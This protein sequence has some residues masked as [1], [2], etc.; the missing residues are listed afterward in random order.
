M[1]SLDSLPFELSSLKPDL[2]GDLVTPEDKEYNDAIAR[3][4]LVAQR[5]A[6]AVVYVKDSEDV[7]LTLKHIVEH[8][9][10][11]VVKGGGHSCS[12]VSSCEGG[13]V[14]DLAR[15][16]NGVSVDAEKKLAYVGGGAVWKSVD[17]KGMEY[18][19]ATVGGTVNH[20]GVLCVYLV[21]A[22]TN[23]NL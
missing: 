2:K 1:G 4:S 21:S 17:E 12:G 3:W 9:V 23:V 8:K 20:V 5:K 16:L 22:C 11:F 14:I 13:I 19:L 6:A 15:Y 7:S 10:P 18:G